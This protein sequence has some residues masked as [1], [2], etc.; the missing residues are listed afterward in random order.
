VIVA[1]QLGV[2]ELGYYSAVLLLIYYPSSMLVRFVHA[3]YMPLIAGARSSPQAQESVSERLGGQTFVL[4]MLML[5]GF[6]LLAPTAVTVLYG[7]R[8]AQAPL[9]VGL[10]GVLQTTRVLINWP[11]TVSLATGRSGAVMMAN[12]FRMLAFPAAFLGLWTIGGLIGVVTGFAVGEATAIAA[13][14]VLMNRNLGRSLTRGFDRL[15][16]YVLAALLMLGWEL[17]LPEPQLWPIS[18]L[19]AATIGLAGWTLKSD[20]AGVVGL[21]QAC[22]T[23]AEGV[24]QALRLRGRRPHGTLDGDAREVASELGRPEPEPVIGPEAEPMMAAGGGR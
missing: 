19:A 13:G 4:S 17:A 8:Y 16:R 7:H 20:W 21:A 3:M 23:S 14:I 18:A 2:K 12:F 24:L 11:T 6:A 5:A 10:I 9:L 1:N 22:R 15:A